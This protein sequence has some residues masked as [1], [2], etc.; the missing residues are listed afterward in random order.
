[1]EMPHSIQAIVEK[2]KA[3]KF[4]SFDP[5]NFV[6]SSAYDTAWLAMVPD[7]LRQDRPMFEECLDWVLKNQKENG[8]WGETD[9]QNNPTID[10][11]PATLACMVALRTW[12]VG[13]INI[14]KG[15]A[16]IHTNAEKLLTE[17][18]D[19]NFPRWF[20]IVFPA[21]VELARRTGLEVVFPDGLDEVMKEIY[22]ERQRILEMEELVDKYHYPPLISYLE[23][24]P[25]SF[26][27]DKEDILVHLSEDGSLFQSPSATAGA[28]MATGNKGIMVYLKS[29]VQRC[30]P[31]V[32]PMYPMDEELIKICMVN[33]IQRLGLAEH[34][35]KE[36]G[37]ILAQVYRNYMNQESWAMGI[38]IAPTQIY[39][40]SLVFRLLRMHGYCVSPWIFCSFLHHEDALAHIE[41][42]YEYFSSAMLNVYRATHLMF[43]EENELQEAR[44]FS[45]KLL[46]NVI[47]LRSTN[48][49]LVI[50]PDFGR[51]IEHE[52]RLPWLARLDHLEHRMW[53]EEGEN[54][55]LW[56]GKASF[57]R[58]SSLHN[59]MLLQLAAENYKFRQSIY[60]KELEDL[61]RWSKHWGLTGMGFGREKTT[62]CYFA[63]AACSSL[64]YDS[65]RRMVV[66]KSA[67]LITVAD[68][69]FD[70][71][72]SLD[73]LQSL[74]EAVRR[75]DGKSLSSHSKVIFDALDN[76]VSDITKTHFDQHGR[77]IRKSLQ[78]IWYETFISWLM[79][80]KWSRS[81]YIPSIDEYLE[82]GMTSIA[83]HILVLS[84]SCLMDSTMPNYTT[85]DGQ[86]ET[87]TK[88]L[89]VS[90]RLLNDIQSY[91]K[92]QEDGKMN[93]ILLYLKENPEA[94]IE[95]SIAHIRKILDEKKKELLENVLMDDIGDMPESWKQLH[96]SCLKVF[97]MFFNSTN[98]YD[99]ET[100]MLHDINKA[101]YLPLEVQISLPIKT[102]PS[103][104]GLKKESS[105]VHARLNQT[106]QHFVKNLENLSLKL[107]ESPSSKDVKIGC[108]QSSSSDYSSSLPS[109]N[110]WC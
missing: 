84:A 54:N 15:L 99:S 48:N 11:L 37:D 96:L 60:K 72:G 82:T 5:Y 64:P 42:N 29:L 59:N 106:F 101:I 12:D 27:I 97:Q 70:M 98:G 52:L 61:K 1:M 25:S 86:Y 47:Q 92:E 107:E 32:P 91:H 80:A 10:S 19:H 30:G 41:K 67:I 22:G 68:D 77:D 33:Q 21:M 17:P 79:E 94:D 3:E 76:L 100:Q 6:S 63:I 57:C 4:S 104:Y 35:I 34:F 66:A 39:K 53:I 78:E 62:Y 7:P 14:E 51:V 36:I 108:L 74:T 95:D 75:W 83:V 49:N 65:D 58:L 16:F 26:D 13:T 71:K 46:E 28:F 87:A 55:A 56:M 23:A 109:T 18:Y 85:R 38:N 2:I 24:L 93:L 44:S 73:E 81:G 103:C 90:T 89:M 9:S 102:L 43:T 69:F 88:L 8:F 110:C 31:G 105:F 50:S 45:R 20:A 40:D